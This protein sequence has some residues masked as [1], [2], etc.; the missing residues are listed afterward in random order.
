M[1]KTIDIFVANVGERTKAERKEIFLYFIDGAVRP[2][3]TFAFNT[4]HGNSA[5]MGGVHK[6]MEDAAYK[7]VTQSNL[8][9]IIVGDGFGEISQRIATQA[10]SQAEMERKPVCVLYRTDRT[11]D[12]PEW[13][14]KFLQDV[15]PRD[16]VNY[17]EKPWR[18]GS[19]ADDAASKAF[20]WYCDKIERPLR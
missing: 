7:G 13:A 10:Y 4:I 2:D 20:G 3:T 9:Y 12:H 16:I 5:A 18:E 6:V 15:R 17:E 1:R 14:E 19:Y 8:T 11:T